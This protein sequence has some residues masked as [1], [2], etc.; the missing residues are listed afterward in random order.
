VS[1]GSWNY[2]FGQ[3]NDIVD[4]LRSDTSTDSHRKLS[5]NADQKEQRR[6]L[7]D[8]LEKVSHAMHSIEWVD[9]FDSSYPDDTAAIADVFASQGRI[10]KIE[11]RHDDKGLLDEVVAREATLHMEDMGSSW[12]ILI[13][14]GA[15]HLNL[16]IGGRLKRPLVIEQSGSVI[17]THP[18]R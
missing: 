10:P 7:A 3:I 9:S 15:D 4:A 13:D 1:G 8:L 17:S 18:K 12:S 2:A 16:S 5:L 11:L 6:K 14:A